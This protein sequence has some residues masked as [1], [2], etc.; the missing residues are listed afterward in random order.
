MAKMLRRSLVIAV[1]AALCAG[2]FAPCAMCENDEVKIVK[3]GDETTAVMVKNVVCPVSDDDIVAG[4]E[5]MVEYKGKIYNL[6]CEACVKHFKKFPAKFAAKAE[7][8]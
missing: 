8:L 5:I 6:C 3:P 4:E 1:A 7:N 2:S